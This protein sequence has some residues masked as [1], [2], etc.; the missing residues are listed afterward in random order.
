MI[1]KRI[2]VTVPAHLAKKPFLQAAFI[3]T[4]IH[5]AG[6]LEVDLSYTIPKG[7]KR[8][9][10]RIDLE[11]YQ[12]RKLDQVCYDFQMTRERVLRCILND[13]YCKILKYRGL[14]EDICKPWSNDVFGTEVQY[15]SDECYYLRGFIK[16]KENAKKN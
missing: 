11:D 15:L 10:A 13:M 4:G 7:V 9:T 16:R 12:V 3:Q 14:P 6:A 1:L 8:G 2:N 5:Y